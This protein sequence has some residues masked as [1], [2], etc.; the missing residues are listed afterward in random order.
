MAHDGQR[1]YDDQIQIRDHID[2]LTTVAQG[3]EGRVA[4]CLRHQLQAAPSRA[5]RA[6]QLNHLVV[7]GRGRADVHPGEARPT[8]ARC[9]SHTSLQ[10]PGFKCA[11]A[12][13]DNPYGH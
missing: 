8:L 11:R 2:V 1:R 6:L 7:V 13:A 9:A 10:D 5:T 12:I 4:G 3:V